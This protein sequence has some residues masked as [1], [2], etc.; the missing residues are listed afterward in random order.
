MD[1]A[2]CVGLRLQQGAHEFTHLLAGQAEA[3]LGI[4]RIVLRGHGR[5]ALWV[6]IVFSHRLGAVDQ[7]EIALVC[8]L[9]EML[10]MHRVFE[11]T[12]NHLLTYIARLNVPRHRGF[13]RSIA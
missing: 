9:Q 11:K 2:P 7:F 6:E 13:I 8:K 10:S 1:L 4:A 3:R 5:L 12:Q